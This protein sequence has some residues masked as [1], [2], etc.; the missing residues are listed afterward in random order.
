M[1]GAT[2]SPGARVTASPIVSTD[3]ANAAPITTSTYRK[4]A[5]ERT[6]PR[7]TMVS[8]RH[9]QITVTWIVTMP[10]RTRRISGVRR[11]A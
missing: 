7:R 5:R 1:P 9:T 4:A 8:R 10:R 6:V 2:A 11:Y 3:A